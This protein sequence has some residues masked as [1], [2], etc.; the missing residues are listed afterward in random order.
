ML[1]SVRMLEK[2][3]NFHAIEPWLSLWQAETLKA[4]QT[5]FTYVLWFL[6]LLISYIMYSTW[7]I[8]SLRH[9]RKCSLARKN[10]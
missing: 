1:E 10:A 3:L 2:T 6:F 7:P 5:M 8:P 4:G 9:T